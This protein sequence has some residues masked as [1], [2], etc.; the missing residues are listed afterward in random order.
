M[1][2][3]SLVLRSC[4]PAI[5]VAA[6]GTS[7]FAW[8]PPIG[9]PAPTF[10]IDETVDDATYTHWVDN[11][12]PCT[13]SGNGTPAAPRCTIPNTLAAGSVV[14]VRGGPYSVGHETWTFNGTA[15]QPAYVRGPSTGPRPYLGN[16]A[17]VE[18]I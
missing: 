5:A 4:L 6:L 3:P 2:P 11:S 7:A 13:D 8:T 10:G 9:I 15:A 1:H 14:Q 12:R 17:D 16:N 18:M